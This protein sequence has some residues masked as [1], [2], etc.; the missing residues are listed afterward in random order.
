GLDLVRNAGADNLCRTKL[1]GRERAGR[2]SLGQRH[3]GGCSAAAEPLAWPGRYRHVRPGGRR[4]AS[5]EPR[6]SSASRP[7]AGCALAAGKLHESSELVIATSYPALSVR[8]PTRQGQ[9]VRRI[10]GGWGGA[11]SFP[12]SS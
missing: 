3:Q 8:T 7:L 6:L 2:W 1:A 9:S 5:R 12:V 11:C 10:A 4:G